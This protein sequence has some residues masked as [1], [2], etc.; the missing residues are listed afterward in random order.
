M[1]DYFTFLEML[2][3]QELREYISRLASEYPSELQAVSG[4]YF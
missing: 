1:G 3:R 2:N 4:P